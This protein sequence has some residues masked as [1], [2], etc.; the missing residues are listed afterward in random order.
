MGFKPD[1]ATS[2][3][4]QLIP[5]DSSV[6]ALIKCRTFNEID[7]EMYP[8]TF[9]AISEGWGVYRVLYCDR[10]E[11]EGNISTYDVAY[12]TVPPDVMDSDFA[13]PDDI[14]IVPNYKCENCGN[15]MI[16]SIAFPDKE[17]GEIHYRCPVCS[18]EMDF[19]ANQPTIRAYGG[20]K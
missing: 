8:D 20:V 3:I 6:C 5:L 11:F 18:T 15:R 9:D 7:G 4:K 17:D 10:E 1:T 2:I 19:Y 12:Y 13:D 16:P 14:I